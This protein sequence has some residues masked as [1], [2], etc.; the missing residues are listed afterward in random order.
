MTLT[1]DECGDMVESPEETRSYDAACTPGTYLW[2]IFRARVALST[3][4]P[5]RGGASLRPARRGYRLSAV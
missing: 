2:S 5:S 4:V 1:G 3:N